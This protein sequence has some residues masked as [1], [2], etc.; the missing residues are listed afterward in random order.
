MTR[1]LLPVIA[2][3][4]LALAL[5]R[6]PVRAQESDSALAFELSQFAEAWIHG[7]DA[8]A[9]ARLE[10]FRNDNRLRGELPRWLAGMRAALA[11]DTG[12][13]RGAHDAL[14]P[15][16]DGANNPR[17]Y[18][19]AARLF[20][21]LGAPD[22]ALAVIRQGRA[23]DAN[24]PALRRFEAGLLWLGNRHEAAVDAY[25]D[26][27]AADGRENY[28]FVAPRFGDWQRVKPWGAA[29]VAA[30]P[31]AGPVKRT[32]RDFDDEFDDEP[33]ANGWQPEPFAD[34]FE[35]AVWYA[36]D[37][38]GM[39]RCLVEMAA[40][41]DQLARQ[42]AAF[43]ARMDDARAAREKLE[44]FRGGDAEARKELVRASMVAQWRAVVA[45]RVCAM[46]DLAGGKPAEAE[47]LAR[48]ALELAADDTALLTLCARALGAQGKAEEARTGPLTRLIGQ[49]LTLWT[50][51]L[52][53][54][55]PAQQAVD[56]V[57]EPALRLLKANREAGKQQLETIRNTFGPEH[58][59][60]MVPQ[61]MIGM[62]LLQRG[63]KE[64]ARHYLS[65]AGRTIGFESGKALSPDAVALEYALLALRVPPGAQA[66]PP[67]NAEGAKEGDPEPEPPKEPA[68]GEAPAQPESTDPLAL[69]LAP[70]A[71]LL[72]GSVPEARRLIWNL[73]EVDF[74]GGNW[75]LSNHLRAARAVPE[76]DNQLRE[77]LFAYHA[78]M[79]KELTPAQLDAALAPEHAGSVAL[80]EA[81]KTFAEGLQQ[82]K[83]GNNWRVMQSLRERSGFVLGMVETRALLLR[84][85][86][87]QQPPKTMDELSAWL[88]G[89][90]DAIDLRAR[91]KA[92]GS[93][94]SSRL[95][96]QRIAAKVPE[97]VHAGLL[98]DAAKALARA[99]D[100]A[101]AARLLWFNRDVPMGI[102]S[103]GRRLFL[104]AL[105][106]RKAGDAL[107]EAQCRL[108]ALESGDPRREQ[109]D[110]SLLLVEVPQL[111]AEIEEF[112]QKGDLEAYVECSI[113]PW[114]DSASLANVLAAAPE[115][116]A[117]RVTMLMRNSLRSG[118]D[119]IFRASLAEG[120]VYTIDQNWLKMIAPRESYAK[121]RRFALW[122][123][124][125]DLSFLG[126]RSGSPGL[127]SAT[128][129]IRGWGLL[130]QL[131]ESRAAYKPEA[132]PEA[133]RVR[134][135]I[136]RCS[137]PAEED[138]SYE[139]E[140]WD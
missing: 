115:L 75:G 118:L 2:L 99:G 68:P 122:V 62:W 52:Y 67:A 139:E 76:G 66:A 103:R 83:D 96:E 21:A 54:T 45:A 38:P 108:A 26:A 25:I 58:Q 123:L 41:A 63:E 40:N 32:F 17:P 128:D 89:R 46:A 65:E 124:A 105:L 107:L 49:G 133:E 33:A 50:S 112:G 53:S 70:R 130:A 125:S 55:G 134:T 104:A 15:L 81:L 140:W 116:K 69:R 90:Q 80:A 31:A 111:R 129:T 44:A 35:P 64:L 37:L 135:L 61:D 16:L 127:N 126:G 1:R 88:K 34:L 48:M 102:D 14:K 73:A 87:S 74:W 10:T 72:L 137:T 19:R 60:R 36:T 132:K 47:T 98:L 93:T 59:K 97:V 78:R 109:T 18:L 28:P 71:G 117:A 56:L 119:G 23:R 24:S 79:G 27:I 22:D 113:V 11:L 106:A 86:L 95:A 114:A 7:D 136:K 94:E 91:L 20:L 13:K 12:D 120:S 131:E 43:S 42:R 110:S 92:G 100:N 77:L 5:V 85:R 8:V 51:M 57:L 9:A 121:C 29:D 84:A 39:D 101:G 30:A 82:A 6:A 4:A 138:D 3:A